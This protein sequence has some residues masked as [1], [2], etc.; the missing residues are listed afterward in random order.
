MASRIL[1]VDLG[2]YS[3][4]VVV[5]NPGFRAAAPA[6]VIER[7]VPPGDEPHE[8]RAARVL[9][10][11]VREN[12]LEGDTPY[13][14]VAGDQV[15]VHVLEFPFKNLRRA[16]LAKAVGGELEGVLPVDLDE[17]VYAFEPLPS[18]VGAGSEPEVDEA[19]TDAGDEDP[20]FVQ[21]VPRARVVHGRVAAPTEGMRVLTCAM[22]RERAASLLEM[23]EEQGAEPRALVASPGAYA[24][25]AERLVTAG[26]V[27]GGPPIAIID[28]GHERTDVCVVKGGSPV[29]FRT[30]KR[31]GRHVTEKIARTWRMSW[32]EAENAKHTDGF[33]G[34][35][36]EPPPSDAWQR[37]HDVVITELG[38]LARELRQTLSAC[39][40][41][42]GAVAH[43]AVL[44][45]GGSRLRGLGSFLTE[46]LHVPVAPLGPE[47][48]VAIAGEA[49]AQ[50]AG[51]DVAALAAGVA[52]E[53]G[54][55]RPAFDLR[56]GE[57]SY[58]TDL[59]FLRTKA[60]QI[61][62]ASLVIVAFA[63]GAA[64]AE[65]YK[66]RKS[67]KVLDQ[68]LAIETTE[69]FGEPLSASDALDRTGG[70]TKAD[71]PLPKMT[72]YDIL[73]A[74]NET[75]PPRSEVTLDVTELD[76]KPSKITFEGRAKASQEIDKIQENLEKIACFKEVKRGK[77]SAGPDDTQTFELT[78]E[79]SCM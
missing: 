10:Q 59:S 1:G 50:Q 45:G 79:S 51:A 64:Y 4:K 41:K 32:Q 47:D 9:G 28:I 25:V 27:K 20:T 30:V 23:F 16:D 72:A 69:I 15:F 11:I 77:Q 31:G 76:I 71:S 21:S 58:K 36:A 12:R 66:L 49:V 18:D 62:A 52:L 33:V 57:L 65:L 17:M 8:V 60:T 74:I 53:G 14:S 29:F 34:S 42:T 70:Q 37:I 73:L 48:A 5:A 56:Q 43:R 22:R 35:V 54:T 78:I 19:L 75:I 6:D 67:E 68:R 61:A 40:A 13:A 3:V 44:V 46:Q 7:L 26:D 24:R 55:G 38:P 39:R 63:A 2:A